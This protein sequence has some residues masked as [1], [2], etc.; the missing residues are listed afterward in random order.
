[1]CGLGFAACG[2][3]GAHGIQGDP[4]VIGRIESVIHRATASG[5]LVRPAAG[6]RDPCGISATVDAKTRYYRRADRLLRPAALAD[7]QLNDTV[8]VYVTGPIAESCPA[9]GYASGVVIVSAATR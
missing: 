6:T 9:Q 8:E 4:Y 1:M 7:L 5:L 3:N 2:S